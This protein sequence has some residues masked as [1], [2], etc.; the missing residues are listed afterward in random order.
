L[1][2]N[3]LF[4]AQ[5]D[6]PVRRRFTADQK[7]QIVIESL[8]PGASIAAVARAHGLNANQLHNWRWQYRHGDL[9]PKGR[10]VAENASSPASS[11]LL[12]VRVIR[13][14]ASASASA[15]ALIPDSIEVFIGHHRVV[16]H[17]AVDTLTLRCLLGALAP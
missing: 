3:S 11:P 15:S 6:A 4:L 7:R 13:A 1:T 12:P 16:L 10:A 17:G 8:Q 14:A 5:A 2:E 9:G